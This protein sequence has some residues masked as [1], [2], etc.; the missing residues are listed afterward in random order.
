M[1]DVS[2]DELDFVQLDR[3]LVDLA[4]AALEAA[5]A[6]NLKVVTAESCT[7]GLIS[8]VLTEAPGAVEHFDGGFVT[9]TPAQKC[10]AL[11]LP[12]DLIERFGAVSAEVASAM[13]EGALLGSEADIAVAVTGVAGPDRDEHGNPVGLVYLAACA[14]KGSGTV[15]IKRSFGAIGRARI[16]REAAAEALKLLARMAAP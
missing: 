5:Q 3:G 14:R 7:G 15:C 8:T 4:I 16:R 9:Y 2:A 1:P 11:K 6:R 12:P 10:R 13:A